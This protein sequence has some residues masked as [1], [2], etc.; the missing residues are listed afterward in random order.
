M[1]EVGLDREITTVIRIVTARKPG[2]ETAIATVIAI[3]IE[4][5]NEIVTE[6]DTAPRKGL[7]VAQFVCAFSNDA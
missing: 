2:I 4:I 5:E 1:I 3:A 7:F 6:T